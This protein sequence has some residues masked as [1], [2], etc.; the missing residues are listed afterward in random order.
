MLNI[1]LLTE[2]LPAHTLA[3]MSRDT[4]MLQIQWEPPSS[5]RHTGYN[6][7]LTGVSNTEH[8]LGESTTNEQFDSLAAGESYTFEIITKSDD[9]Q[10]VM[11]SKDFYTSKYMYCT[12]IYMLLTVTCMFLFR[13]KCTYLCTISCDILCIMYM[14]FLFYFYYYVP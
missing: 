12:I 5:G 8:D 1:Y 4:N 7:K 13:S 6:V 14:C 9:Q 3:V 10:S 11:V 2:P